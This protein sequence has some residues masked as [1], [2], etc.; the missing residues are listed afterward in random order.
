MR[1]GAA[2]SATAGRTLLIACGALAREVLDLKARNG[3]EAFDLAC[4]PAELHNFPGRIPEAAR[5]RIRRGKAD[6]YER[7]FLLYGDCGTGGLLDKVLAEEGVERIEGPHCY[8]F[9]SGN[10]AFAE[11]AEADCAA[12]FL[13]DFLARHFD[14][15]IWEGLKL[16]RHPELLE[17]YFGNYE[18]VVYLAQTEQ[19]ELEARA[20]EIAERLGLEY[21]LR[22]VGYGDLEA[23]LQ[24]EHAGAVATAA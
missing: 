10:A 16:D 15:L 8:S 6:G 18:R 9:F 23:A 3:W 21:E 24:Q 13:T 5:A 20:R 22:R 1:A 19:A 4:L 14:K 7:I 17:V 12:F 11:R 2:A